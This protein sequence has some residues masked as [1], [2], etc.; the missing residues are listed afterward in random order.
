V[1]A[2]PAASRSSS[3]EDVAV[4]ELTPSSP[5]KCRSG[6]NINDLMRKESIED[7]EEPEEYVDVVGDGGM[8]RTSFLKVQRKAHIEFYR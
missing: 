3:I 4:V 7:G 8:A 1:A 6:N 5:K 2:T